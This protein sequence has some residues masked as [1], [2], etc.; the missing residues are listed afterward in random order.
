[1]IIG[2]IIMSIVLLATIFLIIIPGAAG[3]SESKML[4]KKWKKRTK[5]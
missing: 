4:E 3:N 2:I 5:S 1:M